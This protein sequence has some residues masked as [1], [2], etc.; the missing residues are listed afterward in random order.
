[1]FHE[2]IA[3]ALDKDDVVNLKNTRLLTQMK[4]FCSH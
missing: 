3:S 4:V 2:G 1:M